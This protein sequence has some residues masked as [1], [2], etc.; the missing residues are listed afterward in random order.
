MFIY[1]EVTVEHTVAVQ[2]VKGQEQLC[3]PSAHP[4]WSYK[5]QI[6]GKFPIHEQFVLLID[7]GGKITI[8]ST[9]GV[10]TSSEKRTPLAFLILSALWFRCQWLWRLEHQWKVKILG[11]SEEWKMWEVL[12][13]HLLHSN[14]SQCMPRSPATIIEEE[15]KGQNFRT[16]DSK[17]CKL[18]PELN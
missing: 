8:S 3:E 18:L 11:G 9:Y 13:C 15:K 1:L 7:I 17:E 5:Y 2:I 6:S 10:L 16:L 12:T 4:L 14:L